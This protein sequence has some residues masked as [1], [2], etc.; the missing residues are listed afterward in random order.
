MP[1][2]VGKFTFLHSLSCWLSLL[3][4][5]HGN[6]NIGFVA[7]VAVSLKFCITLVERQAVRVGG[8]LVVLNSACGAAS[9]YFCIT[10]VWRL[11]LGSLRNGEGYGF[12]NVT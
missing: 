1:I 8:K 10:P 6:S 3:S 12:E 5:Q 7:C 11:I 4:V 2:S 9:L